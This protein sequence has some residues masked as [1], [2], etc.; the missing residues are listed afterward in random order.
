MQW[1]NA[2]PEVWVSALEI[3]KTRYYESLSKARSSNGGIAVF[4]ISI[5]IM[6]ES[7]S[8]DLLMAQ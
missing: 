4:W 5:I 7:E 2:D 8:L 6:Y 3:I 1:Y